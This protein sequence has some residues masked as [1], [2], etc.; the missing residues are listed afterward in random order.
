[1]GFYYSRA[2]T[3]WGGGSAFV[4]PMK[5]DN[6]GILRSERQYGMGWTNNEIARYHQFAKQYISTYSGRI[7]CADL[8][9]AVLME[10]ASNNKLPVTLKYYQGGWKWMNYHPSIDLG[11]QRLYPKKVCRI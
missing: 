5:C 1:M 11:H 8:A 4:L 9:I 2:P 10:F 3:K 7:D 6:T